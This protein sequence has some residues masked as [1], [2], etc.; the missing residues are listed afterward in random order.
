[1]I[2]LEGIWR[3]YRMGEEELHAL[4]GIDLVVQSGDHVAIMGPS[5]SGKSTLLNLVGLLDRSTAGRY[6][7]DGRF[8]GLTLLVDQGEETVHGRW[9]AKGGR[10]SELADLLRETDDPAMVVL[11]PPGS[12]KS[13]LLRRLELDTAIAGLRA[14]VRVAGESGEIQGASL[15]APASDRITFFVALNTYRS[16]HPGEAPLAPGAY[17]SQRRC[18][19]L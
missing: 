17:L 13:T 3:T 8:V 11:G 4:A 16:A 7:L 12:G 5:G 18:R 9:S 2:S 14:A 19:A 6:R 10:F 1:M 15:R